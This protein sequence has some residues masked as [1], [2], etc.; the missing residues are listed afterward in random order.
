MEARLIDYNFAQLSATTVTGSS[1]D[2]NFPA[3]NLQNPIRR[4]VWRSTGTFVIPAGGKKIDFKESGGGAELHAT[5]TAGTYTPDT[6]ETEIKT[7]LEAAGAET[8]TVTFSTSTGLWTISTGGAYLSI[9]WSTGVNT[10]TSIG[11]IIG[12]DT[13]A[14]DTGATSYTGST[15]AIHTE[16]SVVFDL[17]TTESIDS[18]ALLFD[19][20]S[21][22]KFTSNV[23][24]RIQGNATDSWAAPAVDVALSI[25]STY[26]LASYFWSSNQSYRYWRVKIVDTA[27]PYL[28]VE[29]S[30]VVLGKGRT[31][32]ALPGRGLNYV[33]KDRSE[34][35]TTRYG[36]RYA[37][38][39]PQIRSV[40]F[41]YPGLSETDCATLETAFIRNGFVTPVALAIDPTAT[42][43]DKDR[44]FF[45]GFFSEPF[46]MN[47]VS[48]T[49]FSVPISIEEAV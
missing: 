25:D 21:G 40:E 17:Q 35:K 24:L 33:R 6:L 22:N 27:N 39:Y 42:A 34:I 12:F 45:Y 23:A 4:R 28:Y 8:Y 15:I 9:L 36:H 29:L 3:S 11:S 7:Q 19:A 32:S 20:I 43:Y 41:S 30:T 48:G 46:K 14:D 2:T 5:V 10:A 13:T 37:D 26:G 18:F 31:L 1:E 16:E 38:I 49:K 47:H 44:F